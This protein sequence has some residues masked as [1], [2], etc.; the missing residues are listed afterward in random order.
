MCVYSFIY[1]YMTLVYKI[2]HKVFCLY[3]YIYIYYIVCKYVNRDAAGAFPK[4]HQ[5][6]RSQGQPAG[7][8]SI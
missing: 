4:L 3:I 2:L 6:R 5:L 8:I 1:V 7:W